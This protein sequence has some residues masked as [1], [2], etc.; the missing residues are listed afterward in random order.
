MTFVLVHWSACLLYYITAKNTHEVE[1]NTHPAVDTLAS[2]YFSNVFFTVGL[3]FGKLNHILG[4][5]K[6]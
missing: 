6:Q 3:L 4:E 5:C 1:K 2:M